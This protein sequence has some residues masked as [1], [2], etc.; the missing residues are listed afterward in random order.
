LQRVEVVRAVKMMAEHGD[1]DL[2][3]LTP[4]ELAD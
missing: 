1:M 2:D 3:G 4:E